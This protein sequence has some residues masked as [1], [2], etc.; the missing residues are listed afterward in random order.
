MKTNERCPHLGVRNWVGGP[1]TGARLHTTRLSLF[2]L[3]PRGYVTSSKLFLLVSC[4][5]K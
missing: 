5:M 2:G 1:G 4:I 3:E